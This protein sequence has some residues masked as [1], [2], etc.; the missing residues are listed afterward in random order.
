MGTMVKCGMV[1]NV[2]HLKADF[3]NMKNKRLRKFILS[4][5]YYAIS[6]F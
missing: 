4:E 2:K 3:I 5:I 6:P 1:S